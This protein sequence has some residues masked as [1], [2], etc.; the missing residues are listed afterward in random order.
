M[1]R[2]GQG[3]QEDVQRVLLCLEGLTELEPDRFPEEVDVLP[4]ERPVDPQS[5][6][7]VGLGD[8]GGRSD[9][10]VGRNQDLGATL[11]RSTRIAS[12][13]GLDHFIEVASERGGDPFQGVAIFRKHQRRR[14][15]LG[16]RR[17]RAVGVAGAA[18]RIDREN[19]AGLNPVDVCQFFQREAGANRQDRARLRIRLPLI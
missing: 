1:Q 8:L 13:V 2:P 7:N 3:A 10:P 5:V 17:E 12:A 9:D 19:I 14:N 15:E 4:T 11:Q 16:I 6:A 18:G